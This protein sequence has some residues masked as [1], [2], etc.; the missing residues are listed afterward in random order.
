MKIDF[1]EIGGGFMTT[2]Y[3]VEQKATINNDE[4]S[5]GSGQTG[6]Q[7]DETGGQI[8]GQIE[9]EPTDR[10]MEILG[11]LKENPYI[12]RDLLS[13]K[14]QINQSVI[15]KHLDNLKKKGFIEREGKT[16]GYWKIKNKDL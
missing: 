14:L 11:I 5:T 2:V 9:N 15:Q 4:D 13:E 1:K 8:G 10:Q 16:R 3:Y 6:G 7:I 12:S